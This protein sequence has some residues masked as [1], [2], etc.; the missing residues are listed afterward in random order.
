MCVLLFLNCA[1]LVSCLS[2]I[3]AQ[4]SNHTQGIINVK[5]FLH[6]VQKSILFQQEVITCLPASLL[7]INPQICLWILLCA[8]SCFQIDL[9]CKRKCEETF[10]SCCDKTGTCSCCFLISTLFFYNFSLFTGRRE[11]VQRLK[12]E[13]TLNV[14]DGCVSIPHLCFY[15]RVCVCVSMSFLPCRCL[16]PDSLTRSRSLTSG[17]VVDA[18]EKPEADTTVT[19]PVTVSARPSVRPKH[20]H[21]QGTRSPRRSRSLIPARSKSELIQGKGLDECFYCI[22]WMS[23]V[24]KGKLRYSV[25]KLQAGKGHCCLRTICQ[26][27]LTELYSE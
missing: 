25:L 24:F 26:T 7:H 15:V 16:R 11:F 4:R 22:L 17:Q 12:L 3:H 2:W 18:S 23:E 21:N 5:E 1:R 20:H 8:L 14:H 19:R 9:T 10:L 13:A 27:L 6:N